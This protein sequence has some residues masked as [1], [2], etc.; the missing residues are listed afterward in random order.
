[1]FEFFFQ[2]T[3]FLSSYLIIER[4]NRVK[5]ASKFGKFGKLAGKKNSLVPQK[6]DFMFY[7]TII[8]IKA[9]SLPKI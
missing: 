2:A 1:L 3:C 7:D 5:I 6:D 8:Q 4:Q 9:L